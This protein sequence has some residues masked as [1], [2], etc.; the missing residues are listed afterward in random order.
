MSRRR[1]TQ[2]QSDLSRRDLFRRAACAAVG[3]IATASMVRDLRMINAAAA[4]AL[5]DAPVDYKALIC[6][7]LNGGND[8]NNFIVQTEDVPATNFYGY[9]AYAAARVDLA[10]PLAGLI[11][12]TGRT[13]GPSLNDGHTYGIHPSCPELAALFNSPT[14]NLAFLCNVGTLLYPI[15]RAQY[16]ASPRL[17]PVPPQ[18]F[19]HQDQVVQWQTSIPDRDSRTGWGGRMADLLNATYN[20]DA[21]VSMNLSISSAS[22][23]EVGNV[24]NQYVVGTSGPQGLAGSP[25]GETAALNTRLKALKDISLT[26]ASPTTP[27]TNLYEVGYAAATDRAVN[28]FD[29]MNGAISPTADPFWTVPFPNTTLGRQLKMVAR[30]IAGRKVL[31]H[32]R[33]VFF[34]SVGGY[35]LHDT[36]VTLGSPTLGAHAKLLGE[37]SQCIN[38]FNAA[39]N[40]LRGGSVSPTIQMTSTDSVVGF[41]AS[42]FGRTF[43]IN[44]TTGSDHGWGNHHVVFGDGVMGGQ[45]YGTFPSYQVNGGVDTDTG[46]WIPGTSVDEYAATLAKWFGVSTTVLP[47]IFPNLPRFANPDLGF[48]PAA[49]PSA[50]PS[51]HVV[52]SVGSTSTATATQAPTKTVKPT[53]APPKP[54]PVQRPMTRK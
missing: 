14:S 41:T 20:V 12:L 54:T 11:P 26:P 1:P 21:T 8:A 35:D 42:D 39:M 18:L 5:P 16:R 46:R 25:G 15:T 52:A 3:T 38:A 19:S 31:K 40:Q 44:G 36:Q 50:L 32:Y 33:Q 48:L 4:D 43:N 53:K 28:N 47:T 29:A 7:F 22:T 37:L 9:N 13:G 30:M 24:V 45:L 2:E 49:S 17:I 6:I 27:Q 51:D 23:F 10:L 34:C